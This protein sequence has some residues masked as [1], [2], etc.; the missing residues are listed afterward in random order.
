M[1]W[2]F[3]N[4]N[5]EKHSKIH[6]PKKRSRSAWDASKFD[7]LVSGWSIESRP[8]NAQLEDE[9]RQLRARSRQ[10]AKNDPYLRRFFQLCRSNIVGSTGIQLRSQVVRGLGKRRGEPDELVRGI[11]EKGWQQ[12]SKP[13]VCCAQE[14]LSM[15]D[16]QNLAI[17]SLFRDGEI[18]LVEY[19]Q[20]EHGISFKFMD[21][22]LMDVN[23][24]EWRGKNRVRMGVELDPIGRA[25]AYHFHSTDTTH[26]NYYLF[27]GK[28]YVRFDKKHVIHKF[29][30]EYVNQIRGYPHS[31]AAMLRM[32]YLAGYEEAELVAARTGSSS[33]G[34]IERGENGRGFEGDDDYD[35]EPVIETDPGSWHYLDNGAKVHTWDPSHPNGAYK[36]YV[37]GVL[38]GIASGLG[39]DY[40]TLANDLEGVNFSSLRGGVLESR[41]LWKVAQ[42]WFI[43]HVASDIFCRWISA[44]LVRGLLVFPSTGQ[45]LSSGELERFKEHRFQARRWAWVDPKKDLE[46]GVLAVNNG[47][48]S[49]GDIIREQGGDPLQ[50]WEELKKEN[51]ILDEYGIKTEL[52]LMATP[53][54]PEEVEDET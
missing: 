4:K 40:N 39:V 3:K 49:R 53:D 31:A 16:M 54:K 44:A 42:E 34:F 13:S 10:L 26:S 2:P 46:A 17:D 36:D 29:M 52:A 48:R 28:G 43:E 50:V 38:R 37:K 30:T 25:V 35:D 27:G 1:F 23:Q 21:P 45:P 18:I 41:E 8:I 20:G 7:N 11:I 24:N 14:R 47:L 12:F 51:E 9:L 32:R 19:A 15:R 5:T 33:M 22:E 6:R